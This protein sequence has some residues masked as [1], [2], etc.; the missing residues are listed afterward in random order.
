MAA[1][2]L[3]RD[4]MRPL[5]KWEHDSIRPGIVG[6]V[7][8]CLITPMLKSSLPGDYR[9]DDTYFGKNS[10]L[11]GSSVS[12]G[13]VRSFNSGGGP[14]YTRDSNWGGRRRFKTSHGWNYQDLRA[15]DKSVEPVMGELPQYSWRN[16]IAQV[17]NARTTGFKFPIPGGGLITPPT[18]GLTRG[19]TYPSIVANAGGTGVVGDEQGVSSLVAPGAVPQAAPNFH[20]SRSSFGGPASNG[21]QA[22]R[23]RMQQGGPRRNR[24]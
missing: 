15:P 11:Y 1:L 18:D 17:Y 14:A 5:N 21:E 13:G 20:P 24:S 7:G 16:K 4:A 12:D 6:S 10:S 2:S 22:T 8:D 3:S 9:Y 19:G 23:R